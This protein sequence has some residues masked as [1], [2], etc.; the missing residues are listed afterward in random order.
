MFLIKKG[1]K[2]GDDLSSL[3]FNSALEYTIRRVPANQ[4]GLN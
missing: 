2:Q 4:E 3:L 1:L